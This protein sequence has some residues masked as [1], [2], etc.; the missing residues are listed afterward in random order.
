MTLTKIKNLSFFSFKVVWIILRKC[1]KKENNFLICLRN[2]PLPTL[3]TQLNLLSLYFSFTDTKENILLPL[4]RYFD[5]RELIIGYSKFKSCLKFKRHC[6]RIFPTFTVP[7]Y[8]FSSAFSFEMN[9]GYFKNDLALLKLL[10]PITNSSR[11]LPLCTES[12]TPIHSGILG[13]KSRQF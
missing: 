3:I 10:Q 5:H 11:I 13:E 12:T 8:F 7:S 9:H 6:Y 1:C 2:V 4:F